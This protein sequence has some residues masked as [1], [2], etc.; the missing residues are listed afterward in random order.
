MSTNTPLSRIARQFTSDDRGISPVIGVVLML[1]LTVIGASVVGTA[2]FGSLGDVS[3]DTAQASFTFSEEANGDLTIRHSAG[4]TLEAARLTV[5]AE[6]ST[7][8]AGFAGSVTPGDE[9]TV[10]AG[11]LSTGDDV[12]VK[13]ETSDGSVT[14][15]GSYTV[16]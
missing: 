15:L 7:V 10:D 4:D 8:S 5:T 1:A 6:G 14:I 16:S 9:G 11:D 13:Y 2:V 12:L 3:G